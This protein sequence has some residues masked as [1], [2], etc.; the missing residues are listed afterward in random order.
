MGGVIDHQVSA[1][2][3]NHSDLKHT[4]LVMASSAKSI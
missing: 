2:A 1:S 4:A 3:A